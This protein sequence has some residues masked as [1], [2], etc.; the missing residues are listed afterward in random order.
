V[1][2]DR[3]QLKTTFDR[4]AGL[5]QQARPDYPAELFDEL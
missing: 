5:Y 3:D 4:A 2:A 1:T